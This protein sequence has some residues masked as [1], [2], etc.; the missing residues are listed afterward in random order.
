MDGIRIGLQVVLLRGLLVAERGDALFLFEAEV[1]SAAQIAAG[2][3][4]VADQDHRRVLR[5]SR[6]V[7]SQWIVCPFL[8]LILG[9]GAASLLPLALP[10]A[11]VFFVGVGGDVISGM[12]VVLIQDVLFVLLTLLQLFLGIVVRLAILFLYK[13]EVRHVGAFVV[14]GGAF[15]EFAQLVGEVV[16]EYRIGCLKF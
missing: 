4:S 11:E 15:A 8:V 13:L 3:V 5:R 7:G 9:L 1:Q 10:I 16:R 6:F 14:N 12:W 2:G